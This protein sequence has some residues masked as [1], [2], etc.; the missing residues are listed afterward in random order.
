MTEFPPSHAWAEKSCG[1]ISYCRCRSAY[2][3]FHQEQRGVCGKYSCIFPYQ[4]NFV[5]SFN[6]GMESESIH[7]WEDGIMKREILLNLKSIFSMN[8]NRLLTLSLAVKRKRLTCSI[9]LHLLDRLLLLERRQVMTMTSGC[10]RQYSRHCNKF[11]CR[12]LAWDHF[13]S[14]ENLSWAWECR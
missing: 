12:W 13:S 7:S 11:H 1:S 10:D 8:L 3:R 14:A 4:T 5:E 9:L 6:A 2:I